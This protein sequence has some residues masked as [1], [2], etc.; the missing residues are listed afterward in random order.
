M[1][2]SERMI[3]NIGRSSLVL[4]ILPMLYF[5]K[6]ITVTG[7]ILVTFARRSKALHI[8]LMGGP[9]IW[10]ASDFETLAQSNG[11]IARKFDPGADREIL[12]LIDARLLS[13]PADFRV[14]R[15]LSIG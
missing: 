5:W 10:R 9:R 1:S 3:S 15:P 6:G 11:L 12:D 14:A 13:Q 4:I 7:V 8:C 2:I